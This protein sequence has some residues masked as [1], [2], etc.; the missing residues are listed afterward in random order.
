VEWSGL[1]TLLEDVSLNEEEDVV[2]W[3]LEK[4]GKFSTKSLYLYMLNLG[5][6][7]GRM[8]EMWKTNYPPETEKLLWLCFRG[9]IQSVSQLALRKWP[10]S[11]LCVQCNIVEEVRGSYFVHMPHF[12]I[13]LVCL[14]RLFWV[15]LYS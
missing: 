14:E 7:D 8:I 15:K 9:Q 10:E 2:K 11:M 12:Q 5:V 6:T 1:Q 13:C 4:S 3:E